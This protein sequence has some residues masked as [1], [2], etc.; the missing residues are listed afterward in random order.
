MMTPYETIFARRS[1]RRYDEM[2]IDDDALADIQSHLDGLIQLPGQSANFE[3]VG[4]EKLKGAIAPYAILAFAEHSEEAC[5][6]IGYSLQEVDLWLQSKGFGS[7]WCGM[8]APVDKNPDYRILLGF[9]HTSVPM[10]SGEQDFKRKAISDISGTDNAVVRAARLAP[11]AVN[12]QPW[13]LTVL[14]GQVEA[15]VN[16]RGIGNVIPGK[17]WLFDIGIVLKHIEVALV[18]EGQSIKELSINGSGKKLSVLAKYT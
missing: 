3:I 13:Y 17:L 4:R 16:V 7:V 5:V 11:S 6:N 8:A 1:V 9:G 14:D 10:R 15:K 18:G 2:P 12:F